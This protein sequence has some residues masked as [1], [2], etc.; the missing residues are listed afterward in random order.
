MRIT[1]EDIEF[2]NLKDHPII[3]EQLKKEIEEGTIEA[4]YKTND[5]CKRIIV[6]NNELEQDEADLKG[7]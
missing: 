3:S 5:I 1:I 2:E 7:L 4:F 6:K